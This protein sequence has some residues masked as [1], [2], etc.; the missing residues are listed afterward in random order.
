LDSSFNASGIAPSGTW[1][2]YS[3]VVQS[4]GKII[5]GGSWMTG[6]QGWGGLKR[7]NPDGSVDS[8]YFGSIITIDFPEGNVSKVIQQSDGKILVVG[9]FDRYS[10]LQTY[11]SVSIIRLNGSYSLG[12]D[13]F[14]DSS[15]F[16]IYPNPTNDL[17]NINS[18]NNHSFTSVKVFDLSG[19]M[20]IESS[21]NKISVSNLVSGLYLLKITTETGEITKKFIKE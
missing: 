11:Q 8:T 10:Y 21:D 17:I 19:K 20:L 14:I 3:I 15:D 5:I 2:V 13:T 18:T 16:T 1:S 6:V 9:D 7:L 12:V 4:D